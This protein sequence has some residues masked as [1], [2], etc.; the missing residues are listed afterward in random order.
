VQETTNLKLKKPE[1]TDAP[2]DITVLNENWDTLDEEIGSINT[3][4]SGKADKDLLNVSDVDLITAVSGRPAVLAAIFTANKAD[5]EEAVAGTDDVKYMTPL[6]TKEAI[7]ASTP[8]RVGD[9]RFLSYPLEDPKYLPCNGQLLDSVD[10]PELFTKTGT[11]YGGVEPLE[12]LT[13]I[14]LGFM[15]YDVIWVGEVS[16]AVGS[17]G[18]IAKSTDNW[19]TW[20]LQTSGVTYI[21]EKITYGNGIYVIWTRDFGGDGESRTYLRGDGDGIWTKF[22]AK[23][24]GMIYGSDKWLN[25]GVHDNSDTIQS[26]IFQYST[27]LTTWTTS[28]SS[29]QFDGLKGISYCNNQFKVICGYD[30]SMDQGILTSDDGISW[31]VK[32]FDS[33]ENPDLNEVRYVDGELIVLGDT[34]ILHYENGKWSGQSIA[35]FSGDEIT[36]IDYS[37][38]LYVVAHKDGIASS[39]DKIN[40]RM[41]PNATG[42]KRVRYI[43][44]NW[45]FVTEG[46]KIAYSRENY[47]QFY[48]PSHNDTLKHCYIKV[49][50]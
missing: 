17:G 8:Y 49:M 6:C 32:R 16:I 1:L 7:D 10:Y 22:W 9:I 47:G 28:Y 3:D 23:S 5:V 34:A 50:E 18:K 45:Y 24:G 11:F 31:S 25:A 12:D 35:G 33:A 20:T 19:A 26:V 36:D 30:G 40:W 46:G 42:C 48:L 38:T 29:T 27:D 43:V 14:D 39:S 4:L 21:L 15:V 2:P 13:E 44:D 41:K 37:G